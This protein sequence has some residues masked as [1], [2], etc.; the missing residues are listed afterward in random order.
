MVHFRCKDKM[1][2]PKMA[3]AYQLNVGQSSQIKPSLF[4]ADFFHIWVTGRSD[5]SHFGLKIS[6]LC[7]KHP[8][9]I[10]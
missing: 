1:T 2:Q 3:C 4:Q 5:G 10:S 9:S 7:T 8:R 6:P